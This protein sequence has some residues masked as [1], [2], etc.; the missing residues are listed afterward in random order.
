MF[1]VGYTCFNQY[2]MKRRIFMM[3]IAQLIKGIGSTTY[4]ILAQFLMERFGFRG[5]LVI[6]SAI[7]SHTIFAMVLMHPI[8]WHLKEVLVPI[9]ESEQCI[10]L[11]KLVFVKCIDN[12]SKYLFLGASESERN[13]EIKVKAECKRS[14]F[15]LEKNEQDEEEEN[16]ERFDYPVSK[17]I[18]SLLSLNNLNGGAVSLQENSKSMRSGRWYS[19]I[20]KFIFKKNSI[21]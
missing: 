12:I 5:T 15:D 8:E 14:S 4:P 20:Y 9:N 1:T 3:T 16:D 11:F 2:F 10:Y 18:A 6:I 7:H 17:R 13:V 21:E 19:F